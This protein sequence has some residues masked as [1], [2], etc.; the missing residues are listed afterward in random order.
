MAEDPLDQL[1]S[2]TLAIEGDEAKL[3]RPALPF[4]EISSQQAPAPPTELTAVDALAARLAEAWVAGALWARG[5]TDATNLTLAVPI[6]MAATPALGD[7]VT[8]LA[9]LSNGSALMTRLRIVANNSLVSTRLSSGGDSGAAAAAVAPLRGVVRVREGCLDVDPLSMFAT[10]ECQQLAN[11]VGGSMTIDVSAC[12]E[13]LG[14]LSGLA[15]AFATGG[16]AGAVAYLASLGLDALIKDFLWQEYVGGVNSSL[17]GGGEGGGATRRLFGQ[18]GA[19]LFV[20]V[21]SAAPL[22]PPSPT[23]LAG[24]A[25]WAGDQL[26]DCASD[27]LANAIKASGGLRPRAIA[28]A[29]G[30]VTAVAQNAAN[31]LASDV[32]NCVDGIDSPSLCQW[33]AG[34]IA[35]LLGDP[36]IT[37]LDG[38][39]YDFNGHGDYWGVLLADNATRPLAPDCYAAGNC[40]FGLQLRL[41]STITL[42]GPALYGHGTGA[43][44]VAGVAMR[45][46]PGTVVTL[47]LDWRTNE[48]T[49]W[50]NGV[51]LD[52]TSPR[53]TGCVPTEPLQVHLGDYVVTIDEAA[54][55]YVFTWLGG[56]QVLVDE[57]VEFTDAGRLLC[58][59]I[60]GFAEI[61]FEVV[62]FVSIFLR[63][64]VIKVANQLPGTAAGPDAG[65]VSGRGRVMGEIT[66]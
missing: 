28:A 43:S 5:F 10:Y 55:N 61:G 26:S 27:A 1:M 11:V 30:C 47:E 65:N 53:M 58:C 23:V 50:R 18:S 60:L 62:E 15:L 8:T 59:E 31:A 24:V 45:S 17:S 38:A 32:A 42:G 41:L 64:A 35:Q 19:A 52:Y 44:F 3:R 51:Q 48:I 46:W 22:T 25:Q 14:D 13:A 40:P 9:G 6:Y 56:A 49:L 54:G 29:C 20:S 2:A 7:L 66:E 37:T 16:P 21:S 12:A 4:A 33:V 36:H 63:R 34:E 57:G 39:N